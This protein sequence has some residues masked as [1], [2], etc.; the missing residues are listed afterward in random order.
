MVLCGVVLSAS[1]LMFGFDDTPVPG[2]ISTRFGSIEVVYKM[3]N[4]MEAKE[5]RILE[6]S[7]E[8]KVDLSGIIRTNDCETL[9]VQPAMCPESPKA[10]CPKCPRRFKALAWDGQ[11]RRVYFALTTGISWEN[12]W[13]I[14]N[15]S[16]ITHQTTR[17]TGTWAAGL[18]TGVIS[19][20]G[21]Y[22][23][24]VKSHHVSPA[25]G[26]GPNADLEIVDLWNR[27]SANPAI[28][29]KNPDG[30]GWIEKLIWESAS[31][32]QYAGA[33]HRLDCKPIPGRAFEGAIDVSSLKFP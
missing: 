13:L 31:K 7:H 3:D 22:L 6:G 8:W 25:F 17:L 33:V 32:L 2:V 1:L 21:Q 11:H 4:G 30:F 29:V 26:C 15:Y 12:M 20:S 24:Y 27:R 10:P 19:R 18:S 28:D 14:L 9:G 5:F 16:L 23:A